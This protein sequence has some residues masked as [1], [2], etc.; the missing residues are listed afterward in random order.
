MVFSWFKLGILGPVPVLWDLAKDAVNEINADPDPEKN[1]LSPGCVMRENRHNYDR[2]GIYEG[3]RC[4]INF[5]NGRIEFTP[6]GAFTEGSGKIDVMAFEAT[7]TEG[8]SLQSSLAGAKSKLGTAGYSLLTN[9]CEHFAIWCRTGKAISTQAFGSY[10]KYKEHSQMMSVFLN[11][12]VSMFS[13]NYPRLISDIYSK[14]A[15]MDF[16]RH[17]FA[18]YVSDRA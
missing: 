4:I 9:N 13:T 2:Y 17:V 1:R 16:S 18:K 15:G 7:A 12:G 5:P 8:I 6:I 10:S 14:E 3:E 11:S